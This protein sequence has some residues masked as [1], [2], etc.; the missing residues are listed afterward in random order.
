M[1]RQLRGAHGPL[2]KCLSAVALLVACQSR[3]QDGL[4]VLERDSSGIRVVENHEP[5]WIQ[6]TGWEVD[7]VPLLSLDGALEPMDAVMLPDGRI[8]VL[9][10]GLPG[11]LEYDQNGVLARKVGVEGTGPGEFQRP[12]A[13]FLYQGDSIAVFDPGHR[14]ISVYD[15]TLGYQRSVPIGAGLPRISFIGTS[16]DGSFLLRGQGFADGGRRW[17]EPT[18]VLRFPKDPG[19]VE[20]MITLP[21]WEYYRV[22][23]RGRPTFGIT[24]FGPRTLISAHGDMI[25]AHLQD[26]CSILLFSSNTEGPEIVSRTPCERPAITREDIER[27]REERVARMRRPV[28]KDW[29]Q[30]FY[31]SRKIPVPD[32]APPFESLLF[33]QAGCLWA[34]LVSLSAE[35]E[36]RWWVFREDGRWLGELTLPDALDLTWIGRDRLIGFVEGDT[37]ERSVRVHRL[38]RGEP[39]QQQGGSQG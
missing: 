14:R 20:S 30:K 16:G 15:R 25:A 18:E 22:S 13:V 39:A 33:D 3:A 27:F 11:L 37:G 4:P 32:K 35:E 31:R 7:P 12:E 29:A 17:R 6:D 8:V 26:D 5:E 28:D 23:F 24:P 19:M 9:D 36:R 38:H 21:G 34:G 1:S 2:V 10:G